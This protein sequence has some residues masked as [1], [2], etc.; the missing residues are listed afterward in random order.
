MSKTTKYVKST[1]NTGGQPPSAPP[2][3]I[4]SKNGQKLR[5][6]TPCHST[7]YDTT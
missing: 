3:A 7:P 1:T 4:L 5:F 2:N 6:T